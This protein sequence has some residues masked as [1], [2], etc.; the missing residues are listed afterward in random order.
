MEQSNHFLLVNR[1][2]KDHLRSSWK[3]FLE[4]KDLKTIWGLHSDLEPWVKKNAELVFAL[5]VV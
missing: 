4:E 2:E 5:T 1:K 3:K